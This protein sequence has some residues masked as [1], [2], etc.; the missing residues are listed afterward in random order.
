MPYPLKNG[1]WKATRMI[2][3]KRKE[4]TCATKRDALTWEAAQT[5]EE[6]EK[7]T[8]RTTCL[9]LNNAYLSYVEERFPH[10]TY[11][12]KKR[13]FKVFLK[14]VPYTTDVMEIQPKGI[15]DAMRSRAKVKSG[16]A[17]NVFRKN[18]AAA[19]TWGVKYLG[20]PRDN[21]FLSVDKFGHDE[22]GRYVPTPDDFDKA[23]GAASP[24]DQTFLLTALHTGARVGELFRLMW[25]DIDLEHGTIRLGTRKTKSGGMEYATLPMTHELR[26]ALSAHRKRGVRGLN[27][28][29]QQDGE[30]F[31]SRQHYM[32]GLCK[33]AGVEPFG[34][35]AIRHLSAVMMYHAGQPVSVIQAMLRHKAAGTTERYLK[36][37]GLDPGRLR[38]AVEAVFSTPAIKVE[39]IKK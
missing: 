31:R 29:T 20:L 15:L 28:F 36:R 16:N 14:F 30:G 38:A 32:K 37:L 35:H 12:E 27:V 34:F 23:K 10:K 9:D 3:G 25:S 4:K 26:A 18:M 5:A 39:Q 17:A 11:L 19:W 2:N 7:P 8:T 21:P 22:K 6:W 33:R 1:K 24:E 13:A